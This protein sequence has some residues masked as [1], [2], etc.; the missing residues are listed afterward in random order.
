MFA[1]LI[2]QLRMLEQLQAEKSLCFQ[3]WNADCRGIFNVP[4]LV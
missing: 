1:G 2:R 4:A 3:F